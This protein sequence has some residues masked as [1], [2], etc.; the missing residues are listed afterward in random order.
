MSMVV[1]CRAIYPRGATLQDV[2]TAYR[3]KMSMRG[4]QQIDGVRMLHSN[5]EQSS[6]IIYAMQRSTPSWYKSLGGEASLKYDEVLEI[7]TVQNIMT[8]QSRSLLP[9]PVG[10]PKI[11][12]QITFEEE[13]DLTVRAEGT[14]KI[15]NLPVIALPL[16]SVITSYVKQAFTKERHLEKELI[17]V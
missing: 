9:L 4:Q 11:Q 14:V 15:D 10:N 8:T 1:E 7:D 12:I 6:R 3:K 5:V 13:N 17:V 16:K 2:L